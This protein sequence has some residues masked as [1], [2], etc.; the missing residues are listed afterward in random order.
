M[1][2]FLTT[3]VF[4]INILGLLF[5]HYYHPVL[6]FT[7]AGAV[8]SGSM[9]YFSLRLARFFLNDDGGSAGAIAILKRPGWWTWSTSQVGVGLVVIL[10]CSGLAWHLVR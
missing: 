6:T 8:V 3:F 10:F 2:A 1:I 9:G 4:S 7:A 5:F